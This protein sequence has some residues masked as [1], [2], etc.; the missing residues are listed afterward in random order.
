M[1]VRNGPISDKGR[2]TSI[3]NVAAECFDDLLRKAFIQPNQVSGLYE[4]NEMLRDI[5]LC[6]GP[7][8]LPKTRS[9]SRNKKLSN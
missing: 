9:K 1:W 2:T 3:E 6:I 4:V 7:V 8:P 5:A